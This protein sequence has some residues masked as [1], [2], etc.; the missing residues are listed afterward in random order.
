MD[1]IALLGRQD[2]TTRLTCLLA[3]FRGFILANMWVTLETP[4]STSLRCCAQNIDGL[5]EE[6]DDQTQ[7]LRRR[8]A[9]VTV[10]SANPGALGWHQALKRES[11]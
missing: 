10:A 7:V 5:Q 2:M 6:R 8:E 3:Q 4:L 9:Q 11:S 1:S